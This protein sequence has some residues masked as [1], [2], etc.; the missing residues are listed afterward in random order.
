MY[1]GAVD[2]GGDKWFNMALP[3]LICVVTKEL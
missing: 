2:R 1:I 3:C